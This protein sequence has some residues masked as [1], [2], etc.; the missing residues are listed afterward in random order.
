MEY[1]RATREDVDAFVDNRMEFA[2]SLV[3]LPNIEAFRESTRNYIEQHIDQDDL[4]V[5]LAVDGGTIVSS[6]M[7]CIFT[8]APHP[9]RLSGKCAEV[10]NVY[11]R[12]DYRG[13]G[14]AKKLLTSLIQEAKHAGVQRLI[15]DYEDAGLPLY[16]KLGFQILE[17]QMQLQL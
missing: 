6:C 15:L 13:Q 12:E 10:L 11:T 7:A 8:S 2:S 5:F 3:N 14:H 16:Q 1:R 9:L 4:I 17:R